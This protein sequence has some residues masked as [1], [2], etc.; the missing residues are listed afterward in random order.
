M[1]RTR[2]LYVMDPMC[3][4][5]WGFAPV[6]DALAEQARAAGVPMHLVAGGLRTGQ[7]ASLDPNTRRYILE[8]WHAVHDA[9]GQPF[10][11][12]G[13]LPDGF[14]YDTEPVCRALV[15]ARSL[16][17]EATWPLVKLIQHA[18]YAEGRDVTQAA[19]LVALAETA[20]IPR[21]EFAEA[22]DGA[23][24]HQ[25]TAEDFTWVQ[26]LGIAGF[27]TLLAE[28]DGQLALL[29]NG[30]QGLDALAPLLARW[31]ERATHA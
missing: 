10:R 13:A 15:A 24:A 8:H 14:V 28:R 29:T 21:I 17:E 20:G 16:H 23:A 9:T 22:F 4:W 31:L 5:C 18:F 19:V 3:S 25:A 26:D 6:A 2:L 11:F 27:P 1:A 12:D 30:Y 7:G